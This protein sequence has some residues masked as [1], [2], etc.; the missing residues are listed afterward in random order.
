MPLYLKGSPISK[1]DS[2]C[3][4][5]MI[6]FSSFVKNPVEMDFRTIYSLFYS[7]EALIIPQ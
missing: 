7:T 3:F 4:C 1:I 5:N 6:E 2:I